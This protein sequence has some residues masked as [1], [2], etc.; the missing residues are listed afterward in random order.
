MHWS[1]DGQRLAYLRLQRTPETYSIEI[2]DLK[3]E[4]RT[5][6]ATEPDKW[7]IDFCWLADG[8]IIYLEGSNL[9]Q[10]GVRGHAATPTGKA[11]RI[12]Q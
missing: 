2:C 5:V 3:G 6:V 11:K 7:V 4:S 10:I 8:R 9:W 1:P 12:T